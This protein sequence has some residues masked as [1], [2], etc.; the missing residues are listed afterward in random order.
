M[1]IGDRNAIAVC[2]DGKSLYRN[3]FTSLQ[4]AEYLQWFCLGFFFFTRNK[5]N[6][7][8][9]NIKRGDA[10]ITGAGNRLHGRYYEF[11]DIEAR[12]NECVYGC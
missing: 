5:R 9:Y 2:R 8:V 4:F 3:K 11:L 7:I 12:G 10:G 1:P 6:Y